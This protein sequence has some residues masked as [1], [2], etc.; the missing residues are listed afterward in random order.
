MGQNNVGRSPIDARGGQLEIAGVVVGSWGP[1]LSGDRDGHGNNHLSP[2]VMSVGGPRRYEHRSMAPRGP[3]GWGRPP[4]GWGRQ[5]AQWGRTSGGWGRP[6]SWATRAI[7]GRPAMYGIGRGMRPMDRG[8]GR[9][10][11]LRVVR[12]TVRMRP[13]PT[14][15]KTNKVSKGRGVTVESTE[16]NDIETEEILDDEEGNDVYADAEDNGA[17]NKALNQDGLQ[18]LIV[19]SMVTNPILI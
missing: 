17:I 19:V 9:G 3:A 18:V 10:R 1:N 14:Q 13:R 16:E 11:G 2:H 5:A 8:Y 12:R 15:T 6:G 7:R 4:P